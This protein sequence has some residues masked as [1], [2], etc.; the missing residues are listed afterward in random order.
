M[1]STPRTE[2]SLAIK[3]YGTEEPVT[4]SRLLTA[5]SL[6]AE[7]DGGNL[8][9][10]RFDGTE[11]IRAISFIVR[12]R[13][14]GTYNPRISELAIEEEDAGF[15]VAY[16]AVTDDGLQSFHYSA[17]IR[18]SA[19]GS[20]DFESEG[21]AETAFETNR[22]GFVVLH[23][24]VGVSGQPVVIEHVDGSIVESVFPDLIDPVQP[25]M[26]LR[27]LTHEPVPGLRVTCRMEGDAFEMEDQRNW[28]DASYK[29]YVR[30]LARPWPYLLPAG[31]RLQQ[32]VRLRVVG[33][34]AT[35]PQAR[36]DV[37]LKVGGVLGRAPKLGLGLDPDEIRPTQDQ[38]TPLRALGA[39]ILVCHYDP[40]RDHGSR[41]LKAL[42]DTAALIGAEP[43]LEAVV[44]EVEG[45]EDEIRAL[46]RDVT[47]IG[48][49]F[50]T[51][52]LSPAPD[53]KCTLP[54]SSWPPAPPAEAMF[55]AAREAFPTVRI[56]G[57][58][59]SY[60]TELNRKRPP[61]DQLDLVTFTTIATMHAGDDHSIMEGLE[62]LP[63]IAK[64]ARA[65][66]GGKPIAVGPS[67][68]GM[69]HNPYGDAPMPNPDNIRQAMTYNDPRQRGLLG[70]AWAV[71]FFAR[72]AA[73]GAET[74]T[75]GSTTGPF[76]VLHTP[77]NW[78][79][80]WFD[81]QG[82]LFP[83]F[84]IL[85]GLAGLAGR[86]M[87]SIESSRPDAVQ[88]V[89]V[90]REGKVETWIA[91]LTPHP[92]AVSIDRDIKDVAVLDDE[93]FVVAAT[94]LNV[95]TDLTRATVD[96]PIHLGPFAVAR[97]HLH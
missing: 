92:L 62:S 48:S 55:R 67:A 64:S 46:G 6:T 20:I 58:M 93:A 61:V 69:R 37:L 47:A 27:A 42:A 41:T 7:L 74:I 91:N 72:F 52:L 94:N 30:P 84:H 23:P 54:G 83:S 44:T 12:D 5:G 1:S 18:G 66:A 11:I 19:D 21:E 90:E 53:M 77:Q 59:F 40:R 39:S 3:L 65:V 29:T 13:N 63:A 33:S 97:L 76:G 70:A 49:P 86:P 38:V 25:M 60:F 68:I 22:T 43:W 16:R 24:I 8:R 78:P 15:T 4:P 85:R 2:P 50:P 36:G 82:G 34:A 87:V 32:A 26:N 31:E 57:G 17:R 71:G 14:W 80:P 79:Q 95:M 35:H 89:A 10:I 81:A 56:G 75:I 51:V 88:G 28:T 9:H 45:F 73:G 96:G